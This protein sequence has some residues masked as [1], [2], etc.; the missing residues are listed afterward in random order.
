V[1]RVIVSVDEIGIVKP[2]CERAMNKKLD[3]VVG[4]IPTRNEIAGV[5]DQVRSRFQGKILE[6]RF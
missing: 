6:R 1:E 5:G 4:L 2:S 3:A